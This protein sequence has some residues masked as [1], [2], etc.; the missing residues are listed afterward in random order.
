MTINL[1]DKTVRRHSSSS[2]ET[3]EDAV[4]ALKDFAPFYRKQ[5]MQKLVVHS[6]AD[7]VRWTAESGGAL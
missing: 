4:T 7:V 1:Y 5:L 2:R 6:V 3:R